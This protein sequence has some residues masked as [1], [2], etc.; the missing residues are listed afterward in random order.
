MEYFVGEIGGK[1][2]RQNL[3]TEMLKDFLSERDQQNSNG[4]A[5]D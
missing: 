5:T 4:I 3:P 2:A 1:S